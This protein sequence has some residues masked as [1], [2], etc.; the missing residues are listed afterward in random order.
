M[1]H[2]L[3]VCAERMRNG[4]KARLVLRLELIYVGLNRRRKSSDDRGQS[5][6]GP[7]CRPGSRSP[8]EAILERLERCS[9]LPNCPAVTWGHA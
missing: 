5:T 6:N 2:C 3:K 1:N 4:G 7:F 8:P 9:C